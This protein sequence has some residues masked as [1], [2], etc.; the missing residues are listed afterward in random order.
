MRK[1][2]VAG[3]TGSGPGVLGR[4]REGLRLLQRAVTPFSSS[5]SLDRWASLL[6]RRTLVSTAMSMGRGI[7]PAIDDPKGILQQGGAFSIAES[8]CAGA[9]LL[10]DCGSRRR[11]LFRFSGSCLGLT[12]GVEYAPK[13]ATVNIG[14]QKRKTALCSRSCSRSDR[15]Q[16]LKR[17][18]SLMNKG[19]ERV[20]GIEPP[21]L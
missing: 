14:G 4:D 17:P 7:A 2:P 10:G 16:H 3:R 15:L 8:V 18:P 20:E 9:E 13:K 11:C 19:L 6:R 1:R 5:T 12:H 21:T